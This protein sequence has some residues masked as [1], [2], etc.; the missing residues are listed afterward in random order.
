M[1]AQSVW[2]GETHR[3]CEMSDAM[4]DPSF[5]SLQSSASSHGAV[6]DGRS[7]VGKGWGYEQN[8]GFVGLGVVRN[9]VLVA[10]AWLVHDLRCRIE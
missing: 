8:G 7:I 6:G 5:S 2:G 4:M 3:S 10:R 9:L 1:A